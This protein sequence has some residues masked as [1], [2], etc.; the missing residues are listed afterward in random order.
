MA[1][2]TRVRSMLFMPASRMNDSGMLVEMCTS[3][4]CGV[5][6]ILAVKPGRWIAT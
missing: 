6:A 3:T 4:C 5:V 1:E 2:L